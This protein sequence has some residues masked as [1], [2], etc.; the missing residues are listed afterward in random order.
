MKETKT[1]PVQFGV[2]LGWVVDKWEEKKKD[3]VRTS[4]SFL[5]M[6]E[7]PSGAQVK[8]AHMS[9]IKNPLFLYIIPATLMH[10]F[11]RFTSA[12]TSS[13]RDRTAC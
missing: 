12:W 7:S 9:E 13:S 11:Q 2:K 6:M 8:A 1:Y 3:H 4:S 5:F 10:S